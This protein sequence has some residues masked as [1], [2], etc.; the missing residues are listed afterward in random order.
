M[1]CASSG[2]RFY[3][4]ILLGDDWWRPTTLAVLAF[5]AYF[6]AARRCCERPDS[7]WVS[8]RVAGADGRRGVDHESRVDL[9]GGT[10]PGRRLG[11]LMA[12][13]LASPRA[14]CGVA[15]PTGVSAGCRPH[16]RG[17]AVQVEEPLAHRG[18]GR[19]GLSAAERSGRA[20]RAEDA[21]AGS[22][23]GVGCHSA[24]GA[25]GG[26]GGRTAC[27]GVRRGVR[28]LSGPALSAAACTSGQADVAGGGRSHSSQAPSTDRWPRPP[29]VA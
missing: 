16:L 5:A 7:S 23:E 14:H 28:D 18:P 21:V 19:Q 10:A 8:R 24:L 29:P 22:G 25:A 9:A 13:S 20:G 12:A 2:I 6:S 11:S 27:A 17:V 15:K 26:H 4:P 3:G 1:R